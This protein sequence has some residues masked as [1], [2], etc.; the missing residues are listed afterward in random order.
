MGTI[1]KSRWFRLAAALAGLLA[2]YA[3]VGFKL[4]PGLLRSQAT[5]YVRETYGRE[6][7][8]GEIRTHPFKLQL[9]VTDFALPD[10]D[11]QTMLGL[12][13]L[14]VDFDVSSIWRRALV[15]SE[16]SLDA[17]VIR[18]VIRPDGA[19]NLADLAPAEA[20]AAESAAQ[21]DD[22]ALP[23]IWIESL[24]VSEG[25]VGYADL[26]ARRKPFT[27]EFAPVAFSL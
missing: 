13:R 5:D 6:L 7:A 3:W 27:R 16:V 23:R 25:R 10:A 20:G 11:G 18:A 19:M 1:L 12:R 15:F 21:E 24:D 14:F 8:L 26:S 22:S 17:P 2:L 4:V 9:E